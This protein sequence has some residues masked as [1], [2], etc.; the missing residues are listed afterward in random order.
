MGI[1]IV[2]I[3]AALIAGY[4]LGS[5]NT[6]IIVGKIYGVEIRSKGSGN[7]GTAN[8]M[9]NLGPKAGSL[10]IIG[11]VL[12]GVAAC[13]LGYYI[14]KAGIAA[15]P[16]VREYVGSSTAN[17]LLYGKITAGVAAVIGHNWPVY[18]GFKG[19]K[20]VLTSFAVLIMFNWA[21][22]LISLGIFIGVFLITEYVSLGSVIAALFFLLMTVIWDNSNLIYMV[23]AT[24][25]CLLIVFMHR[26]NIRRLLNGTENKANI[27]RRT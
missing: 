26:S 10:V 5:V 7:A 13:L 24:L 27:F 8:T 1:Y 17:H 23:F 11:D 2:L 4:L 22:A 21:Y 19:G 12:K 20:G 6:S 15:F 9:R 25:L 14:I 3:I 18:F 16:G